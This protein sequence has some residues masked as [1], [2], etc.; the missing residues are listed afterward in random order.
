MQREAV[1]SVSGSVRGRKKG[2]EGVK[3]AGT[4]RQTGRGESIAKK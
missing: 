1:R 4:R 3:V 2:G